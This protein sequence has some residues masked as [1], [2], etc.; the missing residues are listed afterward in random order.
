VIV[1]DLAGG[2]FILGGGRLSEARRYCGLRLKM[3]TE[4]VVEVISGS[5][6]DFIRPNDPKMGANKRAGGENF[7]L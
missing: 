2:G 6:E 5:S 3:F 1:E 4:I 7:F